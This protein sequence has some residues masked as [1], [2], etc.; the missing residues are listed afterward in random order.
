MRE[1][2]EIVRELRELEE[3]GELKNINNYRFNS[4]LKD[5]KVED[6]NLEI[7]KDDNCYFDKS[8]KY[9]NLKMTNI[10]LR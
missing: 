4:Q 5:I 1:E 10:K 9:K 8:F 6:F 3:S 7:K 2:A